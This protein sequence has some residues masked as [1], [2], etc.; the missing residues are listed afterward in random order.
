MR[1]A[2]DAPWEAARDALAGYGTGELLDAFEFTFNSPFVT[3]AREL[4]EYA[5]PTLTP[6]R[7]LVEAIDELTRRIHA[8]FTYKPASTAID[9]PLLDTLRSRQGVCQ[10]FAHLMIGALRTVGLAARYVSGYL[11]SGADHQGAEASHAWVGVFV[12]G[13]GWLDV[14]PTN[15]VR[16]GLGHVTLG[17]GRDYADVTPVK[18]ITHGGGRQ[19]VD[20]EVRVD[21]IEG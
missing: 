11:R 6:G 9:T 7:P 12:P 1:P 2:T 17:W 21:P 3:A 8:E 18:G 15:N 16:A 5:Q 13:Y 10:D 20:V 14:D 4:A 19:A